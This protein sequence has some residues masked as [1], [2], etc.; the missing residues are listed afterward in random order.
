MSPF[1]F[2]INFSLV[3][4]GPGCAGLRLIRIYGCAAAQLYALYAFPSGARR[5]P[6]AEQRVRDGAEGFRF[7]G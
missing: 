1:I 3:E 6:R 5:L 7:A 2:A 4:T